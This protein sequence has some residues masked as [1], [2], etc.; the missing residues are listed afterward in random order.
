[1][2]LISWNCQGLGSSLTGNAL[3]KLC[4]I[5]KPQ[6]LFLMETR[7][8][9]DF[10]VS[11]KRKLKFT[12]HFVVNSINTDGGLA[13]FWDDSVQI[14]VLDYS[15]NY[16]DTMVC[17]VSIGFVCKITLLYGNPHE[18]AKTAF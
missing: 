3:Q 11:W 14:T 15:P 4:K 2:R 6:L 10:I 7:Q 12:K 13:L 18:N 1:M 17:F 5:Q 16:V 9:E 8:P